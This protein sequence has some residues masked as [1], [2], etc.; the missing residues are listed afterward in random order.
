MEN[1]GVCL[2]SISHKVTLTD[3]PHLYTAAGGDR[4]NTNTSPFPLTN[5]LGGEIDVG[6]KAP[7]TMLCFNERMSITMGALSR[8]L[9]NRFSMDQPSL[10][11]AKAIDGVSI[12]A[13]S[14]RKSN[15]ELAMSLLRSREASCSRDP[16]KL[17]GI[18]LNI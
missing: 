8:V 1:G 14:G 7:N 5:L 2:L 9:A 3:R 17:F 18:L 15:R 12:F 16:G 4:R 11:V 6:E 10:Y 13:V